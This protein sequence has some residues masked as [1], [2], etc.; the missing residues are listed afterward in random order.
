M[1]VTHAPHN[2]AA[3][4]TAESDNTPRRS[5]VPQRFGRKT[6]LLIVLIG[7]LLGS[8]CAAALF[9]LDL[10]SRPFA[11]AVLLIASAMFL[12]AQAFRYRATMLLGVVAGT[13]LA[14]L[15]IYIRSTSQQHLIVFLLLVPATFVL[16][17]RAIRDRFQMRL[18]TLLVAV[19]VLSILL[20]SVGRS[21]VAA[22]NETA[23]VR[24]LK[25]L[26]VAVTYQTD[27]RDDANYFYTTNNVR[28]PT[29]ARD[30]LSKGY[31][32]EIRNMRFRRSEFTDADVSILEGVRSVESLDLRDS[33][34][35]AAGVAHM[36]LLSGLKHL[37]L[38]WSQ[39]SAESIARVAQQPDL[40]DVSV[41]FPE[42]GAWTTG[43]IKP[44]PNQAA[45]LNV[46][47]PE[48]LAGLESI[49]R[50]VVETDVL[51]DDGLSAI[52][53]LPKLQT[54]SLESPSPQ[55]K[56]L[57][58]DFSRLAESQTLQKLNIALES[59]DNQHLH[60]LLELR[61]LRVLRLIGT[62]TRF[63]A[64]DAFQAA[65]PEVQILLR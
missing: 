24:A 34:V 31:F 63:P 9:K 48:L 52:A 45:Q 44:L 59:F 61:S 64:R 57:L 43:G 20:A 56:L 7:T 21:I 4:R 46:A 32:S 47:Q 30:G 3:E 41:S 11:V 15:G 35:T 6:M 27:D 23:A 10:T 1:A 51:N 16:L 62:R 28:L 40:R 13:M 19:A 18:R 53:S 14:G 12:I 17:A 38:Q 65:R 49:E 60:E 8:W 29:W 25:E 33:Q 42:T 39:V 55:R 58:G 50:L 22:R 36:P 26:S 5:A 37:K 54:L 2:K